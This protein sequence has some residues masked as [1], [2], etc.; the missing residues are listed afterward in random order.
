[1]ARRR[2]ISI[3]TSLVSV[4]TV[5]LLASAGGASAAPNTIFATSTPAT[6]D[7]GDG[8]A[9]ELGLKFAS[10]V[11]GN[12]TGV[13]FYK[14]TTNLGTHLGSL[15]SAG[16][17]L[18][19]SA[20]FTGETASGWQQVNFSKPVAI[21]AN[22]TYIAGYFAP[23]GHYS[24]TTSGFA[25]G[26]VSNPPL[27]A[28]ANSVSA[29]GVYAYSATSSF[30][31][32]SFKATNYWVDVN[33]EPTVTTAPGQVT[34]VSATAAPG[35][36]T[37]TWSAP[38]SG[39]AV[40]KYTITPYI[41]TTAQPT[42][43]ITGS[44]PLTNTTISGLTNGSTYTFTVQAS[45][46]AGP[47]PVS[48]PS[49]AVTPTAPTPPAAPTEVVATAETGGAK[50]TWTAPS[51]NGSPIAKYTVTPYVGS[52]AQVATT[53]TGSPPAT[54]A[55]ISGL[56]N[57]TTYTFTVSATN[58]IGT[59][60]ESSQSNAVTPSGT[61][62]AYP[63]MALVMPIGEISIHHTATTRTLEFTH[64][65]WDAGAGPLEM[66]PV[67]N[68]KT[69]ISQG[70]QAL[71]TMPSP[72][73][74]KFDHTVPI[75]GPMI[76]EP[77]SDY[78][79]PLDTFGVYT[80]ASGGGVG[81][82]VALSPKALFCMTSDT[83]VG[84]VPNTPTTNEYPS[85]E[86]R[87]PTGRL[88][89]SVGWGDQY[90]ATDGGEG[91]EISSLAN[92]TYWLQGEVDP[93]HYFQ[94]SNTANNLTDTKIEIE[95]N[96]VKVLEQTHP[97][98]T[99][100]TVAVTSPTA[101]ST[102]AGTAT[103]TASAS[104]PAPIASVQFLLDGQ[105]IGAPRTTP[106]YTMQ[107]ILGSTI[108]GSHFIS[109]QATDTIGFIGTALDV[110]VTTKEGS[111]ETTDT[112]PPTVSITNPVAGTIVSGTRQLSASASDNVAV[113]EV[114]FYLDG[115]PLGVPVTAS[116]YAVSWDT[117]TATNGSHTLTAI[118]T[119]TSGNAGN[120]TPVSVTA[121]NPAGEG[122]CFV[123]DVNSTVNGKSTV[124]TAPFTTAEAGEELLAFVSSDGPSGAKAQSATV[125][126]AGLTW[127]LVA[128]ANSQAGDAEIWAARPLT[129]LANATVTSTPATSGYEQSL[130]V[131]AMQMSNGVGASV[132]GGAASGAPSVS[133]K[134]TEDGSLVYAVGEDYSNAISRTLGPNQVM[135]RQFL[136]TTSGN[137]FWSQYTGAITGEAGESVTI[138]DS[139]PTADKWNMAAV[140]IL[141]DGAGK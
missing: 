59:G 100:P 26:G 16:G 4:L 102:L 51:N 13:R 84:G 12:V 138:N 36:A 130:T 42:T 109:A 43:T 125:S 40:S 3:I 60:P 28:L 94:E 74:W 106:P 11:A 54:A 129:S 87:L 15:W 58:G 14:A 126:G 105:P 66:R 23:K 108:P 69:G 79:F 111:G 22:T 50:V 53:V 113:R 44:P 32:S 88:G 25:S 132:V 76:W 75:V 7:S 128:R 80:V 131:I 140:E 39:G 112:Q 8:H 21:A 73:V 46:S 70:Y 63:D 103:L 137:T 107:W 2:R 56:T 33:F 135:L 19:A 64:I 38:S 96:T 122:P 92:G 6:V 141:G 37:V 1:V 104:G 62:L 115:K 10:E 81:S 124:T 45:N 95:G 9:V 116:P 86:C 119:D 117:T 99:P 82:P 67:Y 49:N 52:T 57:G 91:I 5:L 20:T 17:T 34:N 18:L 83:L 139:A 24:D 93:Y 127:T 65:S 61:A 118:A 78:R 77:P 136:D 47:G 35:S 68:E 72:G 101:G 31:A 97:N 41:G 90:D 114:Q 98:S 121:E 134:T 110:A 29:N 123:M 27:S 48:A 71:Y 85:G 89:L 120:A 133:L 30:P 55:T